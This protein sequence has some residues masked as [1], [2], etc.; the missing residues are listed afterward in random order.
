MNTNPRFEDVENFDLQKKIVCYRKAN[1]TGD[2][3]AML[4]LYENERSARIEKGI[5]NIKLINILDLGALTPYAQLILIIEERLEVA[6][7]DWQ[8]ATDDNNKHFFNGRGN[9]LQELTHDIEYLQK[10]ESIH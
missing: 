6:K 1:D 2:V 4:K 5:W 3:K 7:I 9:A 10:G 8:A